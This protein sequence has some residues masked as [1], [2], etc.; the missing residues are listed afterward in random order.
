MIK[1]T[2]TY[3][4]Y[5]GVRRTEDFYFNLSKADLM[6]MN[7]RANG[8]LSEMMKRVIDAQDVP[9]MFEIFED[10]IRESYGVKTPDGRSFVKRSE[11]YEA[12]KSSEAYSELLDDLL[13]ADKCA[14][15]FNGVVPAGLVEQMKAEQAKQ[16]L[17]AA[18]N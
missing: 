18:T 4:D 3:T 17:I 2:I 6:R 7:V 11:D 1:K 16:N 5:N 15:F 14:E 8:D 9:A 13:D 12:F 10:L